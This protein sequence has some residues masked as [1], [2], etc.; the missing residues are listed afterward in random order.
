MVGVRCGPRWRHPPTRRCSVIAVQLSRSFY[1][2]IS[3]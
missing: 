1:M 3:R 2:S